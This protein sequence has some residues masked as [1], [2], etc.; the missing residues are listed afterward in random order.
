MTIHSDAFTPS[1][2]SCFFVPGKM[3]LVSPRVGL[4]GGEINT[5]QAESEE[6]GETQ[7]KMNRPGFPALCEP[8]AVNVA[9]RQNTP[10]NSSVRFTFA[11]VCVCVCVCV[12]V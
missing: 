1:D 10:D 5:L 3:A 12:C 8:V 2:Q 4:S 7:I 11:G 9:P 6:F